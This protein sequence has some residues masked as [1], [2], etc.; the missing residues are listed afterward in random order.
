MSGNPTTSGPALLWLLVAVLLLPCGCASPDR[1]EQGNLQ[2]AAT[3]GTGVIDL[4]RLAG[5]VDGVAEAGRE[6]SERTLRQ[7]EQVVREYHFEGRRPLEGW[8]AW[9]DCGRFL[10]RDGIL[11]I[12]ATGEDFQM[13]VAPDFDCGRVQRVLIRARVDHGN[14]GHL[15]WMTREKPSY[16]NE[17]SIQFWLHPGDSFRTYTIEVGEDEQWDGEI[18][19]IRLD[20]IDKPGT[21]EID[22]VIFMAGLN[23]LESDLLAARSGLSDAAL[24]L[25]DDRRRV[26]AVTPGDPVSVDLRLPRATGTAGPE[27][28]FA[29]GLAAIGPDGR[30]AVP[31]EPHRFLVRTADGETIFNQVLNPALNRLHG[32]WREERVP[33]GR[34]AG[35]QLGLVFEV[36]SLGDTGGQD[37]CAAFANPL[38][39]PGRRGGQPNVLVVLVDA[40]RADR[41]GCYGHPR[42]TTPHL[43]RLRRESVLFRH[44]QSSSSWTAPS[45]ASLFTGLHPY[46]HG[47][48][49]VDTLDL[50]D[51]FETIAERFFEAGWFTG[52]VSDNML[53][54]PDNGFDQGFRTFVSKPESVDM[55][56]AK[57]VTSIALSW[58]EHHGDQPFFLY[59]HYMD[60]HANYQPRQP[61]HPG[62][63]PSGTTIRP[64]VEQ[65][66]AGG[67]ANR[68]QK[69]RRFRLTPAEDRRLIDL[70]DGEISATDHQVGRLLAWLEKQGLAD[71]TVV[72]F[73]ADHGEEFADHGKYAHATSLFDEL[74]RVPLLVRLPGPDRAASRERGVEAVVRTADLGP[75]LLEL[76]GASGYAGEVEAG[77][78]GDLLENSGPA[79]EAREAYFE[80]NPYSRN[81]LAPGWIEAARGLRLGNLKLIYEP[82]TEQYSLYDLA[83]DPGERRSIFDAGDHRSMEMAARL[84]RYLEEAGLAEMEDGPVP[85]LEDRQ[86]QQLDALGY[87]D[88]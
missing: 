33:L 14:R 87:L 53:I 76:A 21:V 6:A 3:L 27:L 79:G 36:D 75:T 58:L 42:Q 52:A 46:R 60:P 59:L 17:R 13:A 45:V 65:G 81:P 80:L 49:Y 54:I 67:V 73:V 55:R 4:V 7:A 12:E 20:P 47:I 10:P 56:K 85:L 64:F 37:C 44:A 41:L 8:E 15:F 19:G 48:R 5:A 1:A 84:D 66:Q 51:R 83:A 88:R 69:S 2:A 82:R 39:H 43:D 77:L 30:E 23:R 71:D 70:Y 29:I 32:S 22:S 50:A 11:Q 61:F 38:I 40:L 16:D 18:T 57:A 62:P 25:R 31:R 86:L 63:V 9:K 26:L 78:F 74:V 24:E 28:R 72:V 68:M 35:D 34:F